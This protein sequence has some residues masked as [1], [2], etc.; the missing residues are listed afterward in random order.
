MCRMLGEGPGGGRDGSRGSAARQRTA[1][2]LSFARSSGPRYPIAMLE[3]AFFLPLGTERLFAFLHR[4]DG[5]CRGGVVLCAPL[6]EEKLWAHRVLVSCARELARRGWAAL[7]F[8]FR[9]EGDSDRDFAQ[10]DL[11][12][13]LEDTAAAIASLRTEVPGVNPVTLVGLRFGASVAALAAAGRSDIGRLVLW[14]PVVDGSDY[15]QGVLRANL[16]AQMAIHHKVIEGR[17][18]LVERLEQG[19]TVNIEGYDFGPGLYRELTAMD[20]RRTLPG[21]S[22][23]TLLVSIT[24]RPAPAREALV[25][26]AATAPR[27]AV[28][29]AVEEPFW[30]EIKAFYQ[31]AGDLFRVTLDWLEAQP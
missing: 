14:D 12:T 16:M 21:C 26:L 24:P 30:K 29:T 7:R 31:H 4:P 2:P 18:R 23:D 28:A 8:D 27:A 15:V 20:L 3:K 17:E 13:R 10:A 25:A 19:G 6:A 9:G 11:T 1:N 5:E 22:A